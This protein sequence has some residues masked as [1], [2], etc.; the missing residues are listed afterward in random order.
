MNTQTHQHD[1]NTQANDAPLRFWTVAEALCD[2]GLDEAVA[3]WHTAYRTK[4]EALQAVHDSLVAIWEE[5]DDW[6]GLG[7]DDAA[8]VDW[9]ENADGTRLAG[10]N[11][12]F[13]LWFFATATELA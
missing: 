7:K 10:Y 9:E 3:P 12:A 13:D 2:G 5:D 8:R 6:G 4:H 1:A 11:E